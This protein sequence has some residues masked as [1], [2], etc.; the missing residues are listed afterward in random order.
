M[1]TCT[2]A[3]DEQQEVLGLTHARVACFGVYENPMRRQRFASK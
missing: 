1:S 2:S 3:R